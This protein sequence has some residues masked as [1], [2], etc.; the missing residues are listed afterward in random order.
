[1][2]TLSEDDIN[3][4]KKSIELYK[5]LI[6]A[7]GAKIGASP[8]V[9][10]STT[11][12]NKSDPASTTSANKS[13]PASTTV[14]NSVTTS[15]TAKKT[16]SNS[17][18]A[19]KSVSNSN[20]INSNLNPE[21]KK[22]QE[23]AD[24]NS[25]GFNTINTKQKKE[26]PKRT[27]SITYTNEQDNIIDLLKLDKKI[28]T[29][30]KQVGAEAPENTPGIMGAGAHNFKNALLAG[31]NPDKKTN[32]WLKA[33]G[34]FVDDNRENQANKD[35]DIQAQSAKT[36]KT[37]ERETPF[38]GYEGSYYIFTNAA[39]GNEVIKFAL[40]SFAK[41]G[42]TMKKRNKRRHQTRRK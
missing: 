19:N 34:W 38:I 18:S 3:N 23:V 5:E 29:N 16:T 27:I 1:M 42:K 35:Y 15:T 24:D 32:V 4:V 28:F 6:E 30:L 26:K 31:Y 39:Q 2:S 11:S 17:T 40:K 20:D 25:I 13:A 21:E 10:T 22:T 12:A 8:S 9:S 37:T 41:G 33:D 7:I 36:A 14:D